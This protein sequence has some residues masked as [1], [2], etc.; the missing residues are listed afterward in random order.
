MRRSAFT[1]L[2]ALTALIAVGA[3]TDY[4][5]P[6]PPD[7]EI[8]WPVG[9]TVHPSGDYLYVVNSNFD[10]AYRVDEGGTIVTLDAETLQPVGNTV[11]IGSFGAELAVVPADGDRPGRL[12]VA[13]RGDDQLSVLRLDDDGRTVSCPRDPEGTNG[14]T[15]TTEQ[16]SAADPFGV[17]VVPTETAWLEDLGADVPDDVLLV[18]GLGSDIALVTCDFVDSS[19]FFD[20]AV[21]RRAIGRGSNG[22]TYY[23]P[24]GRALVT[25]RFTSLLRVVD[26]FLDDTGRAGDVVLTEVL[27]VPSSLERVDMRDLALSPDFERAYLTLSRPDGLMSMSLTAN[28]DGAIEARFLD[29][30]D[31]DGDPSALVVRREGDRD[32]AYVALREEDEVVVVDLTTGRVDARIAVDREGAALDDEAAP[33]ALALDETR[34]RL[35][36]TLFDGDEVVAIDV[37][38]SGETFRTVVTRSRP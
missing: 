22:I 32:V 23:P 18:G 35:Y 29:R 34:Q 28:D 6:P 1:V 5:G 19:T 37:D 31:L 15:C 27:P 16:R 11:R 10:S 24:A 8:F 20:C 17:T 25:G 21:E 7:G 26:W 3:C 33:Y 9:V 13:V 38:P 14:L 30:F 4:P 12:Y 36:V 2:L